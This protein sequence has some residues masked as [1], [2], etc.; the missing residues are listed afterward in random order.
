MDLLT[1]FFNKGADL[2]LP[3]SAAIRRSITGVFLSDQPAFAEESSQAKGNK[4]LKEIKKELKGNF[5]FLLVLFL[6]NKTINAAFTNEQELVQSP[7]TAYRNPLGSLEGESDTINTG[8]LNFVDREMSEVDDENDEIFEGI[9]ASDSSLTKASDSSY[10]ANIAKLLALSFGSTAGIPLIVLAKNASKNYKELS[11]AFA[12]ST[13]F[14]IGISRSWG[15]LQ[16]TSEENLLKLQG[17]NKKIFY[18]KI[19]FAHTIG[20]LSSLPFSYTIYNYNRGVLK[21]LTL[22]TL[23]AEYGLATY[24][25]M[26]LLS[27]NTSGLINSLNCKTYNNYDSLSQNNTNSTKLIQALNNAIPNLICANSSE[28][29]SKINSLIQC[30]DKDKDFLKT[31]LDINREDETNSCN[32]K[33]LESM[34]CIIPLSNAVQNIV[35]S[36][37]SSKAFSNSLW[38]SLGYTFVTVTPNLILGTITSRDTISEIYDSVYS[39]RNKNLLNAY[40]PNSYKGIIILSLISSCLTASG[41]MFLSYDI[42]KNSKFSDFAMYFTIVNGIGIVIFESYVMR[43]VLENLLFM[44]L[45]RYGT[46][47]EKKILKIKE[48]TEKLHLYIKFGSKK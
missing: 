1:F 40:Y 36:L 7:F 3:I 32:K 26:E 38:F 33:L 2:K 12:A 4:S 14:S 46:D 8:Q 25:Y 15:L 30:I 5:L 23:F 44:Y 28:K 27:G 11:L 24:G 13:V 41:S 43:L 18:A 42:I 9:I 34:I 37:N 29:E 17:M 19:I 22:S 10:R 20:I 21:Y 48:K 39:V 16:L 31:L 45:K 6:L 47:E 35:M